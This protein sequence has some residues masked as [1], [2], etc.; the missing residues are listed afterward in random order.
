M[1]GLQRYR[2][3]DLP[4]L[5]EKIHKNS[6]GLDDY[7]DHFFNLNQ[8][9]QYPPYNLVQVSNVESRLEVA[10]AGFKKE[11]VKVFTEYGKLFVQGKKEDEKKEENEYLHRGM[12]Q[13]SFQRQWQL[14]DDST[15]KNVTFE[16]GMLIITLGKIVP[17]HHARKEYL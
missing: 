10:L 15:I 5:M 4:Q 17:E 11:E 6:I 14:S 9:N 7:F 13:R 1:T 12:A 8:N 2:A 3:A 16:D